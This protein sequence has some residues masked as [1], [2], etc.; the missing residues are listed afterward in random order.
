MAPDAVDEVA[1]VG[2]E[3]LFVVGVGTVPRIGQPEVLPHHDAVAVAGVVEL[4]V[5]RLPHPVAYHVVVHVAVVGHGRIVFAPAVVEVGLGEAPVAA[6][7]DETLAVDEDLQCV[8][9]VGIA[10]LTDSRLV[11]HHRRRPAVGGLAH[12]EARII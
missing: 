4:I 1:A 2:E 12:L 5:A 8:V 10:H 7:G 9:G 11:V 3:Q 6:E